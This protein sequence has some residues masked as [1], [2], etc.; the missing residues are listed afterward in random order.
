MISSRRMR[1]EGGTALL[2]V[3]WLSAAL[4]AIAFTIASSVRAETERTSTDVDALRAGYLADGAIDRALLYIQ[5]G[6]SYRNP[7]GTPKYF[8]NPTPVLHFQFPTGAVNVEI[9]PETAKL[10]VNLARPEEI[11]NLLLVMGVVPAQAEAITAAILDWRSPTPGGAFS[12]FDQHYLSLVPS[13]QARHASFHE[14]EELLLVQGVTPDLFYGSYTRDEEGHLLRHPA[15][16][17]CLSV[18]GTK[19]V[20]D[21]NTVEP[22]VM[23]AVGVTPNAVTAIVNSRRQHVIK[24]GD[25]AGFLGGA[26][27][28]AARLGIAP[29]AIVTLRATAALRLPNGQLSDLRRSVS[30]MVKMLGPGFD[31]PYHVMRWYDNVVAPQ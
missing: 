7:D 14:I 6:P 24:Q 3:L 31:E 8:E 5:W 23:G 4:S 30:A 17:D 10:N 29:S 11:R 9:I 22:A 28:G 16:R 26:G 12:Q 15:L 2:A 21:I 13:F 1:T 20:L 25:V 19:G 27:P 18:F